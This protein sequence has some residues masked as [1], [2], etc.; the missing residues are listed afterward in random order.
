MQRACEPT[1]SVHAQLKGLSVSTS[2][3]RVGVRSGHSGQ[4]RLKHLNAR[5]QLA[6]ASKLLQTTVLQFVPLHCRQARLLL[7]MPGML[8]FFKHCCMNVLQI[9]CKVRHGPGSCNFPNS[10]NFIQEKPQ[11]LGRSRQGIAVEMKVLV[12][13]PTESRSGRHVSNSTN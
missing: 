4:D 2:G 8:P 13:T 9:R 3:G 12:G 5:R 1:G 6:E 10:S 7:F 11:V